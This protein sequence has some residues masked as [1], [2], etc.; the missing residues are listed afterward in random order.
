MQNLILDNPSE[1]DRWHFPVYHKSNLYSCYKI[2]SDMEL[3]PYDHIVSD[4]IIFSAKHHVQY[5]KTDVSIDNYVDLVINVIHDAVKGKKC[6]IADTNGLDCNT[7]IAVMNY[8]SID[9]QTYTYDGNRD[10]H[11]QWY[12]NIQDAHWGFNQTPYFNESVNLVTGM[13]GDEYMLRNPSYVEQHCKIDLCKVF[14]KYKDS[15]MYN[16]FEQGYKKK[17]NKGYNKNWLQVLLNDY[18]L[19]SFGNTNVINPFKNK[20]ILIKG[21]SLDQDT[22][23]KQLTDGYINKLI[24]Q[25]TD[26][27]RLSHIHKDKNVGDDPR[28]SVYYN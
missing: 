1:I 15:Y 9:Y 21:L 16:F 4:N 24:I 12:R 7:I 14:E 27:K 28:F 26:P 8:F 23:L 10:S 19:W 11:P 22:I 25:Q 17:M 13:Y 6:W 3:I 18:Q 5:S 20:D 2:E